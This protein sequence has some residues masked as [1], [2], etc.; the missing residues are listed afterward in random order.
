M[1]TNIISDH[2]LA[3]AGS[4]SGGEKKGLKVLIAIDESG[5]S[6][7]ALQWA[8]D[9]LFPSLPGI[10]ATVVESRREVGMLTIMN[11]IEPFHQYIL[12]AGPAGYSS[13]LESVRKARE[14]SA[15]VLL[16]QALRLCKDKMVKVETL[17]VEGDPKD[18]ICEAGD[19][20]HA[21][22][23]VLGSRGLGKIKRAFMGSVS[24]YCVH[25]AK[26]PVL[27]VRPQPHAK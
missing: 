5:E 4:S 10:G 14:E 16:A 22:L 12:P 1:A 2:P 3:G 13:N 27:I 20:M 11:V 23:L 25:H 7:Y 26:C 15:G 21:D 17:I 19:E 18:K 8:L 24:D 6:F 9:H